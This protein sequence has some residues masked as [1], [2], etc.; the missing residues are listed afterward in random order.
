MKKRTLAARILVAAGLT[1]TLIGLAAPAHAEKYAIDDP[2][3]ASGSLNDIYGLSYAHS[4]KKVR[5]V[6]R[7]A[8]LRRVSSAGATVFLDT[9]PKNKGPEYALSTGL[10]AGTDYA[11][12]RVDTWRDMGNG[13]LNCDYSLRLRYQTDKVVGVI[14]R[15]CLKNPKKV[16]LSVKMADHFDPSHPIRDWAPAK[17]QFGLAVAAG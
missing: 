3:D 16:A 4:D 17:K 5:F 11:L 12:R 13:P 2:A 6:I 7:V 1:L 15:G 10:S 14:A 8:D 9:K